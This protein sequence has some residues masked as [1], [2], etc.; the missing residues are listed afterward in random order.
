M[1][2]QILVQ[3]PPAY[4]AELKLQGDCPTVALM[5][6]PVGSTVGLRRFSHLDRNDQIVL[7]RP[8]VVS[9]F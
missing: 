7:G 1:I 3:P 2:E 5:Q 6:I 4:K 9:V 8:E